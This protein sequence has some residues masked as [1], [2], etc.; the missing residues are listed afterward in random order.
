MGRLTGKRFL[1]VS[2][3]FDPAGGG[4]VKAISQHFRRLH[5]EGAE[6]IV[7]TMTPTY[8]DKDITY[9][10][11]I[12]RLLEP[13]SS[14]DYTPTQLLK[15]IYSSLGQNTEKV[16]SKAKEYPQQYFHY[17]CGYGSF[18]AL[19]INKVF[20]TL[21]EYF[22]TAVT[23][24]FQYDPP[25]Y[26]DSVDHWANPPSLDCDIQIVCSPVWAERISG[27]SIIIPVIPIIN[28]LDIPDSPLIPWEER[29]YDFG[30]M[31]PLTHKG[32]TL[33]LKLVDTHTS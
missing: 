21:K 1:F 29:K 10:F 23:H 17:L 24:I 15:L 33:V 25:F 22:H 4:G 9:P 30:F 16:I 26:E 32:F 2:E 31:N 11:T 5:E 18:G 3:V 14:V 28:T 13:V 12:H 27:G 20:T 19:D 6:V 7:I 8:T